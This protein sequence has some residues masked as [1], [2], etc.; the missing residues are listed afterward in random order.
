MFL[1]DVCLED[2][3]VLR[4]NQCLIIVPQCRRAL[5][6]NFQNWQPRVDLLTMTKEDLLQEQAIEVI[7]A[8][9]VAKVAVKEEYLEEALDDDFTF[10]DINND[11]SFE[12]TKPKKDFKRRRTLIS[13]DLIKDW[14]CS[15]CNKAFCKQRSLQLHM[16]EKHFNMTEKKTLSRKQKEWVREE[17]RINRK[18]IKTDSG[19][20][21]EWIC[22][23]CEF[24]CGLSKDFRAHVIEN[25]LNEMTFEESDQKITINRI[26]REWI[27][28]QIKH[29]EFQE[30]VNSKVKTYM[31]LKCGSQ[32]RSVATF[33][34]HLVKHLIEMRDKDSYDIEQV[35]KKT[36]LS[37]NIMICLKCC[38]QFCQVKSFDSHM[39]MHEAVEAIIIHIKLFK[40]NICNFVFR[41]DED[42]RIHLNGHSN[43]ES[44]IV[45]AEGCALQKASWFR[46]ISPD[47][48]ESLF[49]ASCGHCERKFNCDNDFKSHM[50]IHHQTPITCPIDNRDFDVAFP[51]INHV[52][53]AHPELMPNA[54]LNCTHCNQPFPNMF[55]RLAHMKNC[56]AKRFIC[57]CHGKR[58]SRKYEMLTHIKQA[59]GLLKY[60]CEVCGKCVKSYSELETHSRTHT[61]LV[62]YC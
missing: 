46:K 25:H 19:A 47:H 5:V 44:V 20:E 53:R 32:R 21:Y 33:R 31:C 56:Q 18:I 58:F 12:V 24:T 54:T 62:N 36:R 57:D 40:C 38:M 8:D 34:K 41:S 59:M 11:H 52:N 17:S 61:K 14:N 27:E 55:D 10:E 16:L 22:K 9:E 28:H 4:F 51:F 1:E 60:S 35:K 7:S 23:K 45:L 3:G 49:G 29:Q 50:L 48:E 37:S 26:Q 39:K 13:D 15:E 42:M 2:I 6:E 43:N 30:S